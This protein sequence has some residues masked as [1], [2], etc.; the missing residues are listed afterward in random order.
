M[1]NRNTYQN[2]NN[3]N[4]KKPENSKYVRPYKNSGIKKDLVI[5]HVILQREN[6]FEKYSDIEFYIN[7]VTTYHNMLYQKLL[8]LIAFGPNTYDIS[9]F[10]KN[11]KFCEGLVIFLRR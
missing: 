4:E 6:L 11:V 5:P 2:L 3:D 7:N 1:N 9:L 8:C 10:C